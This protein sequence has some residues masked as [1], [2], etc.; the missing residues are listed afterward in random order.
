M[1]EWA[2]Y[3]RAGYMCCMDNGCGYCKVVKR[4]TVKQNINI[5]FTHDKE[6]ILTL[7]HTFICIAIYGHMYE[8]TNIS[9]HW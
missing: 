7:T 4:V 3:N 2:T 5:N 8:C 1:G 6:N 9:R